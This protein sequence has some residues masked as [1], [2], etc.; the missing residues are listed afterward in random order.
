MPPVTEKVKRTVLTG[1]IQDLR[2][3]STDPVMQRELLF[4]AYAHLAGDARTFADR[5]FSSSEHDPRLLSRTH[6]RRVNIPSII[7]LPDSEMYKIEWTET[8]TPDDSG[9]DEAR[10]V[11]W[12]AYL[13]VDQH[14]PQTPEQARRNPMGVYVTSLSWSK[15]TPPA[16]K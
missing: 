16:P 6:R 12:Q 5:Y 2:T 9:S 1:F 11:G 3:V 14:V 8:T 7:Q 4:D 10:K 13:K 15:T